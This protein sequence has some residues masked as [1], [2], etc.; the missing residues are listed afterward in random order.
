MRVCPHCWD[1][2]PLRARA[3]IAQL[4]DGGTFVEQEAAL[5]SQDPL[6]FFDLRPYAER[7]AEAE[8]STGLADA[9]VVGS[10]KIERRDCELAVMD[11]AF[12]GGSRGSS[13]RLRDVRRGDPDRPVRRRNRRH[14]GSRD[15]RAPRREEGR[16]ADRSPEG[17][18]SPGRVDARS[19]GARRQSEELAPCPE[20]RL[21]L[22]SGQA[23][24]EI[25]ADAGDSHRAASVGQDGSRGEMGRLS[26]SLPASRRRSGALEQ[27]GE[28][29]PGAPC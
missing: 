2:F 21:G 13:A 22:P 12:M 29:T 26:R 24:P 5:H 7:L 6:R 11:F 23:V 16:R 10:A 19:S 20:A 1:H 3:R 8:L 17:G 18:A 4:A 9:M 28:G 14:L 25:R 27:N 15:V